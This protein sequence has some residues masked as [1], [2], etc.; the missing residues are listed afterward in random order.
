MAE[1][2]H[3]LEE[4]QS[5]AKA[6]GLELKSA[7]SEGVTISKLTAENASEVVASIEG[8]KG[9]K[10]YFFPQSQTIYYLMDPAGKKQ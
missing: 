2:F 9:F 7:S 4:L 6:N 5:Y 3:S 8:K 10:G 1:D